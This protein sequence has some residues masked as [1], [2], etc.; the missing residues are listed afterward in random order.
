M[1]ATHFVSVKLKLLSKKNPPTVSIDGQT[2]YCEN[3]SSK[4]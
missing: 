1:I 2:F 4:V 3:R